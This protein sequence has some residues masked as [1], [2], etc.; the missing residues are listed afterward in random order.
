MIVVLKKYE[1]LTGLLGHTIFVAVQC[2]SGC[3]VWPQEVPF[4]IVSSRLWIICLG[5][6]V[7]HGL[8]NLIRCSV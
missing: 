1:N 5:Q 6:A 3:T 7:C 8:Y 2:Y 4:Y